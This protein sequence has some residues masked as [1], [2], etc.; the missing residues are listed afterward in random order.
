MIEHF[1]NQH[2][3]HI[4]ERMNMNRGLNV[5]RLQTQLNCG[6]IFDIRSIFSQ[7]NNVPHVTKQ[8]WRM[9]FRVHFQAM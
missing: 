7:I 5:K 8:F 1:K 3:N 2:S 6:A 4:Y 9:G